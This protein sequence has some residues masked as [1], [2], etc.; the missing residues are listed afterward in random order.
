M[1]KICLEKQRGREK[2]EIQPIFVEFSQDFQMPGRTATSRVP[3][4][5]VWHFEKMR[6]DHKKRFG[7]RFF[8]GLRAS[9]ITEKL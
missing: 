9:E 4:W 3:L 8:L 7:N 2:I 1:S 6:K 5:E